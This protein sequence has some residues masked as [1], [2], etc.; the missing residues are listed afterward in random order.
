LIYFPPAK[1]NLGLKVLEKREDGFHNIESIFLPTQLCDVLEVHKLDNGNNGELIFECSGIEIVGDN[2][3]NTVVRAHQLLSEKFELPALE[4]KLHKLIPTGAGLGG[5]SADGSFMLKAINEICQLGLSVDS[6]EEFAAELGSDCP[7]FVK[8]IPA[9]VTGRGEKLNPIPIAS[10]KLRFEEL[11]I[12]IIHPN[13]H[14]N[15]S[16][17]FSLLKDDKGS[18]PQDDAQRLQLI[19][20][21]K[22]QDFCDL[23]ETPI[24]SWNDLIVNEFQQHIANRFPQISEALKLIDDSGADYFQLTGSGSS[25][26]GLYKLGGSVNSLKGSKITQNALKVVKNMRKKGFFVYFGALA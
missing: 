14:V 2:E 11:M 19:S 23:L 15:T 6:L 3:K 13:V 1:I 9:M 8:N 26:Y 5:G 25:V 16:F 21:L 20:N 4:A 12:L 10:E 18:N 24:E 22:N 17:A 7:F